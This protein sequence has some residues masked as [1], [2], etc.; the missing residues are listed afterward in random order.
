MKATAS[1]GT[2]AITL[3]GAVLAARRAQDDSGGIPG[4]ALN[5]A[6]SRKV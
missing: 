3:A 4:H 1:L 6:V 2:A 5:P